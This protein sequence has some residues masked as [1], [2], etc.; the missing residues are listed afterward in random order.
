M[1][2]CSDYLENKILDHV[3]GKASYTAP[4]NIYLA[5]CTAA[6]ID[7]DDGDSITE[8][9]YTNYARKQ[10]SPSDWNS[11]VSGAIDNASELAFPEAGAG[12]ADDV[13]AVA[14]LDA[15]SSGNLL[16]YGTISPTLHVSQ[17]VTPKFAIGGIEVTQS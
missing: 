14:L 6:V 11:A 5:L 9:D 7:T 4:T 2:Q 13:V 8:C 3:F 12:D 17:G 10:T 16:A 1:S 15:A